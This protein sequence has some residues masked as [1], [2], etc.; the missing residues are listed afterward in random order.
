[1]KLTSEYRELLLERLGGS[2]DGGLGYLKAC[3]EE[4]GVP[5][6]LLGMKQVVDARTGMSALSKQI[7]VT[8][9][10]LYKA[11]SNDGNPRVKDLEQILEVLGFRTA[12]EE[13]LPRSNEKN[14]R[15]A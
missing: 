5:H 11:L 13:N 3:L 9:A 1:M 14:A 7:G 15:T 6:L 8:R 2:K 12:I 10:T 4:G